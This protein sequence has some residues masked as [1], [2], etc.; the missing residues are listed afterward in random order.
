MRCVTPRCCAR[1]PSPRITGSAIRMTIIAGLVTGSRFRTPSSSSSMRTRWPS[2]CAARGVV[3]VRL[4]SA[5]QRHCQQHGDQ[6]VAS[7][8][9]HAPSNTQ[10]SAGSFPLGWQLC[11]E[12]AYS[13]GSSGAGWPAREPCAAPRFGLNA[14]AS[15]TS[16]PRPPV[17]STASARSASAPRPPPR[18]A[19][20]ASSSRSNFGSSGGPALAFRTRRPGTTRCRPRV[21]RCRN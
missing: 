12:Q 21:T 17:S 18:T 6:Q 4:A 20:V 5:G 2:R 7:V 19:A 9:L 10:R 13:S 16:R 1:P 14:R 15:C 11:T 8:G 3:I